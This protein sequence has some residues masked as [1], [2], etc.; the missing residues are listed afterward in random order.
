MSKRYRERVEVD[1]DGAGPTRFLWRG[2]SYRVT[3]VLGHW[4]EDAGYWSARGV[5]I[6]QRDLWRVAA[7]DAQASR[8]VYELVREA[9]AWCLNR[10][11]D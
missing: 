8:G 3:T 2:R 5:E 6:P 10:I 9:D 1:A 7:R 4:R 11:W